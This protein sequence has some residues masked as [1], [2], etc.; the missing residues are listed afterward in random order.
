MIKLNRS[1]PSHFIQDTSR[2][3]YA[4]IKES[5]LGEAQREVYEAIKYKTQM[6]IYPTDREIAVS[7][8]YKD[9]NKVRPRRFELVAQGLVAEAGR[10][11]CLISGKQALTW[12]VPSNL[13]YCFFLRVGDTLVESKTLPKTEWWTLKETM[14]ERGYIYKGEGKWQKK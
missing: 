1:H 9:P 6:G 2:I 13:A 12:C 10:R 14:E 5:G 3:S 8:G 11:T 7:L 4:E